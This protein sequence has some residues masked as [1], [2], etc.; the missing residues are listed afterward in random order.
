MPNIDLS[1][2]VEVK[3]SLSSE[4]RTSQTDYRESM[5]KLPGFMQGLLTWVTGKPLKEQ[6]LQT[7]TPIY[8][9][10]MV[11]TILLVGTLLS[12][13]AVLAQGVWLLLLLPGWIFTVSGARQ[14]QV[15]IVHHCAH[16]NFT[17][18]RSLDRRLGQIISTILLFR[19]FDGYQQDH[20]KHH[21]DPSA[22][23]D[24]TVKF[25]RLLLGIR[26]GMS[27]REQ[28]QRLWFSLVSPI[29]HA[30][31]L[32]ARLISSLGSTS[33]THRVLTW[34]SLI[35]VL[36]MVTLSSSWHI[37]LIVWVFPLTVLYQISTTLRL[38]SEHLRLPTL[39]DNARRDKQSYSQATVGIFLGD[40][41]PDFTLPFWSQLKQ[42]FWWYLRLALI[43]IPTRAFILVGDCPHH[44]YHH[45]HPN[46]NWANATV[47]RQQDIDAGCPSWNEPYREVAGLWAAIELA[48]Q[49]ISQQEPVV[50]AQTNEPIHK[51]YTVSAEEG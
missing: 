47:A 9:L 27:V 3:C 2:K 34:S 11:L 37:F 19:E 15:V 45:R 5:A 1:P 28:W 4:S 36:T 7:K 42:W 50:I 49:S 40:P 46:G 8:H 16:A 32:A 41:V 44:D 39:K 26:E 38:C 25:L 23:D 10:A 12:I 29:F 48:F 35:I 24:E 18:N 6:L 17:R 20:I 13:F 43:H 21:A 30:Q 22:V 31:F 51:L 14:L 33:V